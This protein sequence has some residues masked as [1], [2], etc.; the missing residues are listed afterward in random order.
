MAGSSGKPLKRLITRR[1]WSM[2]TTEFSGQYYPLSYNNSKPNA[3]ACI[4]G[5]Q[6]ISK[7]WP[8]D[9]NTFKGMVDANAG[10]AGKWQ[11][12]WALF[13]CPRRVV[14]EKISGIGRDKVG[15]T[16]NSYGGNYL[17]L[18]R[19]ADSVPAPVW[20]PSDRWAS[21]TI[22]LGETSF[23]SGMIL[24]DDYIRTAAD[25]N[26]TLTKIGTGQPQA[27]KYCESAVNFY[28]HF[29]KT[30]LAANMVWSQA[31]AYETWTIGKEGSCNFL[32]ANG[33]VKT[34]IRYD[35]R[36]RAWT[37]AAD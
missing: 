4:L 5:V 33:S 13:L 25:L 2:Y 26:L 31:L 32:F 11:R 12:D 35:L 34:C 15:V 14:T 10:Q 20:T 22:L 7:K 8:T 27:G 6:Y 28:R 9:F 24:W 21:D 19:A 3:W 29:V 17:S 36:R 37:S 30:P 1:S 16:E 23:E 18:V